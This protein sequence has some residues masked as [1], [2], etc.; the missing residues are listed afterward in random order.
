MYYSEG[1]MNRWESRLNKITMIY[2]YSP[3]IFL[4][5]FWYIK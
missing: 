2:N 4:P 3:D 1:N 5:R